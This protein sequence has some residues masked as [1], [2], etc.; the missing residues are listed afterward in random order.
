MPLSLPRAAFDRIVKHIVAMEDER[1]FVLDACFPKPSE[2]RD[3]LRMLLDR[4]TA[5]V[6]ELIGRVKVRDDKD[7]ETL[8]NLELP[9]V[10]V[11]SEVALEDLAQGERLVF[12]IEHPFKTDGSG[13]EI[14]YISPLGAA[15]LL[16]KPGQKVAV[17]T[18]AGEFGYRIESIHLIA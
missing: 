6:N 11:G 10:M 16:K 8:A 3:R 4:Y 7:G 13:G 18:P 2:E 5:H 15:L 9:F 14:S 12:R 17:E 1:D